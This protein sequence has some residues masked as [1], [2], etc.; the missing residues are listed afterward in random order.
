MCLGLLGDFSVSAGSTLLELLQTARTLPEL[1]VCVVGASC[2]SAHVF[3][4]T[5]WG[6]LEA[7]VLVLSFPVKERPDDSQIQT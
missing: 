4:N 3:E 5:P 1:S 6:G 7:E 2:I